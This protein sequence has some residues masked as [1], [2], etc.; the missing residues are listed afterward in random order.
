MTAEELYRE[1]G[2]DYQTALSRMIGN[3]GL[4]TRML[5]KFG[6]DK[7]YAALEKAMEEQNF[8]EIFTAAHTLKGVAGNLELSPLFRAS[9]ELSD[10]VRGGK[11]DER[12]PELFA[13]VK[14]AYET[15]MEKIGTLE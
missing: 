9:A 11:Q 10:A 2:A 6:A 1:I 8:E 7:S 12:V 13:A 3:Q 4:L 5:K 14:D 15:V